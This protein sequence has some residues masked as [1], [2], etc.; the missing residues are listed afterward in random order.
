LKIL[1][2]PQGF[3]TDYI[4]KLTLFRKQSKPQIARAALRESR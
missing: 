4:V 2:T 1:P 3:S